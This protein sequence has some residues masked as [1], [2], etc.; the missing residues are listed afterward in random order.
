VL[1][2]DLPLTPDEIVKLLKASGYN[3]KELAKQLKLSDATVSKWV[4]GLGNPSRDSADK[5]RALKPRPDHIRPW[6]AYVAEAKARVVSNRLPPLP[7]E[8]AI[9]PPAVDPEAFAVSVA[10]KLRDAVAGEVKAVLPTAQAVASEV[11]A[12][13]HTAQ[14]V[15]AEVKATLPTAQDVAAEVKAIIS[16]AQDVAAE[17]KAIIPTAQ[18]LA[19][20][21]KATMP[22]PADDANVAALVM[23]H[24]APYLKFLAI[25]AALIVT[26]VVGGTGSIV[27]LSYRTAAPFSLSAAR[28]GQ[29][30]STRRIEIDERLLGFR[31]SGESS[32]GQNKT[33]R[34]MPRTRLR[35]K[36]LGLDQ[37][38][39]PCEGSETE[40]YGLCWKLTGHSAP[41][42]STEYQEGNR[43]YIPM[44]DAPK[45]PTSETREPPNPEQR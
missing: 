16:T 39:A 32:M 7:T 40:L 41:C 34:P 8:A 13:I 9:P 14:D 44:F 24:A 21:V 17:V 23:R 28:T 12:V 18:D 43:C 5:L 33:G 30:E 4:N 42:P 38:V 20:E 31:S 2:E 45:E 25:S 3:Q 35:S 6:N 22:K 1:P 27:V 19:A 37:A 29:D 15:A 11:K 26:V 10:A 36:H